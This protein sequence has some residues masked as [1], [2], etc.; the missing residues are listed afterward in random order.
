MNSL[1]GDLSMP[2]AER[3]RPPAEAALPAIASGGGD[4][5]QDWADSLIQAEAPAE[6]WGPEPDDDAAPSAGDLAAV[7]IRL[8]TRQKSPLQSRHNRQS[9][10]KT[11][12]RSHLSSSADFAKLNFV[13]ALYKEDNLAAMPI[14]AIT[15][16]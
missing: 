9:L 10:R 2:G 15:N 3:V 14:T 1:F 5:W 6:D 12:A 4:D 8:A 13:A 16:R 11:R 7:A